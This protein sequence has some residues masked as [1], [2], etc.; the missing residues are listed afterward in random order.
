MAVRSGVSR[1]SWLWMLGGGWGFF[2]A[3]IS[4]RRKAIYF[5]VAFAAAFLWRYFRRLKTV[6]VAG[7]IAIGLVVFF[8]VQ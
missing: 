7:F 5:I 4:G 8:I 2:N 1:W 3:L 6:Q